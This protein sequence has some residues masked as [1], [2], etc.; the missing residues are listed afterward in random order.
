MYV[1]FHECMHTFTNVT[2]GKHE[3]LNEKMHYSICSCPGNLGCAT[4]DRNTVLTYQND[5]C[6]SPLPLSY[7][8]HMLNS[9]C[10]KLFSSS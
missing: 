4:A 2:I 9:L 7:I 6:G 1:P 5:P 8:K 10:V 3:C